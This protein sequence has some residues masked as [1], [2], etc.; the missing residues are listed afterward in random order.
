MQKRNLERAV[1]ALEL[2]NRHRQLHSENSPIKK[3]LVRIVITKASYAM[4]ERPFFSKY[5]RGLY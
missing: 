4:C 5:Q 1:V 3:A 2:L